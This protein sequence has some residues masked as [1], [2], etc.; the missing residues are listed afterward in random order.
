MSLPSPRAVVDLSLVNMGRKTTVSTVPTAVLPNASSLSLPGRQITSGYSCVVCRATWFRYSNVF[1][2][3]E[4]SQAVSF[5]TKSMRRHTLT[6]PP[7]SFRAPFLILFSVL[8][9]FFAAIVD[10]AR[11]SLRHD[12]SGHV[13]S[14][15]EKITRSLIT[16]REALSSVAAG[17]RFLYFWAFVAQPPLCEQG[18]GSFLRLHSGSWLHWGLTG[19]VLRSSTF[20]ASIAI[21]VL[22]LL[23]RLVKSMRT[24]GP[25]YNV[26]SGLEITASTIYIV[27]LLLNSTIVEPACRRETLWQYSTAL[28]ALF[29]NLGVGIGNI[30]YCESLFSYRSVCH[31][32]LC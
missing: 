19:T 2:D 22:Q 32:S 4:E 21:L 23:W 17:L 27:K 26:E 29:I 10:L 30:L 3:I 24:L 6:S 8:F 9:T 13:R 20:L 12:N 31:L 15:T 5:S 18:S 14:D 1:H 11:I 7:F 25:I 28:F 16:A